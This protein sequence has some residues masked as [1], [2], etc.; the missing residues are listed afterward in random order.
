[1]NL[2]KHLQHPTAR[3]RLAQQMERK[4][5]IDR[6]DRLARRELFSPPPPDRGSPIIGLLMLGMIVLYG[7]LGWIILF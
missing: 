6:A 3:T 4:E 1:M 2:T 7:V 5:L